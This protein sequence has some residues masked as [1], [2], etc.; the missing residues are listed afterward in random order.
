MLY[1]MVGAVLATT[2]LAEF[3]LMWL[4]QQSYRL[5]GVSRGA[6]KINLRISVLIHYTCFVNFDCGDE[7]IHCICY[8]KCSG[9]VIVI[10][11]IIE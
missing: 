4:R 9:L 1:S 10:R 5:E 6:M 7:Y 8:S 2:E 11:K 3:F